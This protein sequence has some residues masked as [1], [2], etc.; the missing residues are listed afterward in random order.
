MIGGAVL[1]VL[2]LVTGFTFL[3]LYLSWHPMMRVTNKETVPM[4]NN[5]K[6][7]IVITQV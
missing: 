3:G 1:L 7:T 6:E 4:P 5:S 2:L